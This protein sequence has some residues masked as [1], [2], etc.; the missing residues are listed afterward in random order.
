MKNKKNN[1]PVYF[2]PEKSIEKKKTF[3]L[4]KTGRKSYAMSFMNLISTKK[5][6][7]DDKGRNKN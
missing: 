7:V 4:L 1:P 3:M 5:I 6:A 2:I